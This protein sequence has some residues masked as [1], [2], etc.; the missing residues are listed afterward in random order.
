MI[1]QTIAFLR[2]LASRRGGNVAIL[3]AFALIPV[4]IGAG[5][6]IDTVR[7]YS[8][9]VR[10]GAA[11]DAAALA[12]G[13]ETG[14]TAGQLA[15]TLQNYFTSNYPGTALGNNVTVTPVP[16][17]ADLTA[18]TVNYQAQATVPMTFMQIVGVSSITVTVTSQ[19]QKTTGL[20]VALVL[21]N[22]GS[23]LCGPN[24]GAPNYS[25]AT[26]QTGVVSSD[27]TCTNANNG[28]RICTLINASTEFINTLTSA[29]SSAQQLYI[30]VVPY[31]TTVN[32]GSALCSGATSCGGH[33]TT[34]ST[35]GL[36]NGTYFTDDKGALVLNTPVSA[37]TGHV[38]S[39]S[40]NITLVSSTTGLSAGMIV[41]GTGIPA[42]TAISSIAGTTITLCANATATGN[43]VSLTIAAPVQYDTTHSATTSNWM[44]CVVEPT[45]SDEN[46][47]VAGVINSATTDP[48]YTEPSG[49]WPAWYPYWWSSDSTNTWTSG[50]IQT[51]SNTT[52]TQGLVLSDW[53]GFDGPNQ[54]CP[55]PI[56]PLTDATTTSGKTS[57]LNTISSMWPRD[58]GGTQVHIGMIWGWRTLSPNGP[59]AANNG[60]P[61]S[62]ATASNTGWKKVIVLMTDGTEEWPVTTNLTGLGNIA[63]GQDQYHQQHDDS[64]DQFEHPADK[65][66]HQPA[67][68]RQLCD[69]H[70]RPGNR[71]RQQHGAAKLSGKHRRLLLGCHH[72]QS[73][74]RVQQHREIADRAPS[75]PLATRRGGPL[76]RAG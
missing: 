61:L 17:N 30:S 13:S 36:C 10:L 46:S 68:Q 24:D 75:Q 23:M 22:T 19:T 57:I 38:T 56:L 54:G 6:A 25:D 28:S 64:P 66:L 3:F 67:E 53:D 71:R 41:T 14:Q 63:D 18:T 31:V 29:I 12:V 74:D 43:N 73:A 33:I 50:T 32:V 72:L 40:A 76:W 44:G 51:Q 2:L 8:V 16:A 11:L 65:S 26:C 69:L 37:R 60:H 9:K 21:D 27:T 70:D 39:G 62:Y 1:A 35:A 45:R 55:V 47:S 34:T 20:E 49:G 15:T 4:T 59:F 58:A 52:E 42:N 7:A 5:M 48:D